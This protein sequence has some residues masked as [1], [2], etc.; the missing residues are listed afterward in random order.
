MEHSWTALTP[1]WL[2]ADDIG[3]GSGGGGGGMQTD[4]LPVNQIYTERQKELITSA[5]RGSLKSTLSKINNIWTQ[6]SFNT[7]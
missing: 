7:P 1:F 6:V 3:W 2:L 5:G 4:G